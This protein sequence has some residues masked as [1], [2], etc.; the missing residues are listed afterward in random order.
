MFEHM[1][2]NAVGTLR[3]LYCK[4]GKVNMCGTISFVRHAAQ[5][6]ERYTVH[7]TYL[8]NGCPLHLGTSS[9]HL[10]KKLIYGLFAGNKLI[11]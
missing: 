3:G 10:C 7:L 6:N 4:L 9:I 11:P 2:N 8:S 1:R 5:H